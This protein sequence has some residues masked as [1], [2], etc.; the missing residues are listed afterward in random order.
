MKF[1]TAL[2][3]IGSFLAA[4]HLS[5]VAAEDSWQIAKAKRKAKEQRPK[6]EKLRG[7]LI[8]LN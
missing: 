7:K 3:L 2:V 5:E 4:L 1:L 6:G 8:V